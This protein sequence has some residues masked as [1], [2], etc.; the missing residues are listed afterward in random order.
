MLNV[1]FYFGIEEGEI[2]LEN[3]HS[4][5]GYTDDLRFSGST[6][7]L[8]AFELF[9]SDAGN[10]RNLEQFVAKSSPDLNDLD[11]T[12]VMGLNVPGGQL[13]KIKGFLSLTAET[14][15]NAIISHAND[16]IRKASSTPSVAH[17]I[18]L[19]NS[20]AISPNTFIISKTLKT[21]FY[22]SF[23]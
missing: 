2:R 14:V 10:Q 17:A 8:G 19:P 13:W 16:L 15:K 21:P 20:L 9:V 3:D 18:T 5:S 1:L 11:S 22:A 12:H 7:D 6:Q 4:S 23:L